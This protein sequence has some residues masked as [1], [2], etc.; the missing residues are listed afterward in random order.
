MLIRQQQERAAAF[1]GSKQGIELIRYGSASSAMEAIR[2]SGT[3]PTDGAGPKTLIPLHATMLLPKNRR[4]ACGH[5][6]CRP[7]KTAGARVAAMKLP[8]APRP[9]VVRRRGRGPGVMI[10]V[11]GPSQPLSESPTPP[12]FLGSVGWHGVVLGCVPVQGRCGAAAS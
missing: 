12:S 10:R 8:P 1:S 4:G 3:K 11:V 6:T 9:A 7:Q 2:V 5:T